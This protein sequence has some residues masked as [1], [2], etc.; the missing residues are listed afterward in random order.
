MNSRLKNRLVPLLLFV[1]VFVAEFLLLRYTFLQKEY[2]GLF[3]N[4][5]DYWTDLWNGQHPLWTLAGDFL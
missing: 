1:A 3:L 4:T 2:F 5:P